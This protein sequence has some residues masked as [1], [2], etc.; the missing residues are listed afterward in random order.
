MEEEVIKVEKKRRVLPRIF[1]G[2][3]IVIFLVILAI[4]GLVA[5]CAFDKEESLAVFPHDYSVYLHVDSAWDTVEPLLDLKAMDMFLTDEKMAGVRGMFMQ[6]RASEWRKNIFLS[7]LGSKSID[8]AIYDGEENFNFIVTVDLGSLSFVSRY[9]SLLYNRLNI[10]GLYR[11]GDHFIFDSNGTYYYIKPYKNLLVVVN[12]D[13]L[14]EAAFAENYNVY[15]VEEQKLF[16]KESDSPVKVIANVSKLLSSESSNEVINQVKYSIPEN[17]LSLIS[18]NITDE[19]IKINAEIPLEIP[20]NPEYLLGPVLNKISTTP[21]ILSRFRENVQYYTIINAGTLQ[22]LKTAFLPLVVEDSDKLWKK[23]DG[24]SKSFFSLSLDELLFSWT[25]NEITMFGLEDK[26]DP[27]F[28]IQVK[29]EKQRQKVFD[30][31]TASMLIKNN[32]SL[33]LDGVRIPRL[34]LPAFIQELLNLFEVSLPHPYYFIQ[35]GFIYFSESAEN[36]S[37]IYKSESRI[38]KIA[39]EKNWN[40]ISK[41]LSSDSTI[42]LYYNLERSIPFFIKSKASLSNMLSLYQTG[43]IDFTLKK[44]SA[45]IQLSAI[46]KEI[47]NGN[48]IPGFPVALEGKVDGNLLIENTAE[49]SKTTALYWVENKNTIAVMEIPSTSIKRLTMQDEVYLAVKAPSQDD[50]KNTI[51]AVTNHGEV[52]LMNRKLEVQSGFPM[53]LGENV[54]I[55]PVTT[56]DGVYIISEKGHLIWI[57]DTGVKAERYLDVNGSVKASPTVVKH[58]DNNYVG[59]YDKSFFGKVIVAVEG[60]LVDTFYYDIPGI[61]FGSPAFMFND[62][63]ELPYVSLITQNGDLHIWNM[64]DSEESVVHIDGLFKSA[65]V[66]IGQYFFALSVDG[67]LYRIDAE[68]NVLDVKIPNVTCNEA[69]ITVIDSNIYICPDGNIIY[70]FDTNLEL[71]YSF[72]ITGWGNPAF[73]DVNGDNVPDCFSLSID[74]KLH[75]VKMRGKNE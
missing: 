27:V 61:A 15:T 2:L 40:T 25:G 4:A 54:T 45:L 21:S 58:K 26:N 52:Y 29:D 36:L 62:Q 11:E 17:A 75:A 33:I 6:L 69:F 60:K 73:A 3:L 7:K 57:S 65:P 43:R 28:A 37:E 14:L 5:F 66:A 12:N 67:V 55:P 44:S 41:G 1:L 51:W 32:S 19:N 18:L 59:I 8:A 31:L 24:L 63:L 39:Q 30:K 34:E 35:D 68:G 9:F 13:T 23:A 48:S 38:G 20:N 47:D 50:S 74:N 10:K 49:K 22:E 71:L 64:N 70:G 72:P 53:I 42:S 56:F 46:S 16:R